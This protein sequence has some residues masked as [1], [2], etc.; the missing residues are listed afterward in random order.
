MRQLA[1]IVALVLASGGCS[2]ESTAATADE[3][4]TTTATTQLTTTTTTKPTT[5]TTT[6]IVF[7]VSEEMALLADGLSV[8]PFGTSMDDTIAAVSDAL[9]FR[10]TGDTRWS[11]DLML[12]TNVDECPGPPRG[13]IWGDLRLL[14]TRAETSWSTDGTPHFFGWQY[15]EPNEGRPSGLTTDVGI[16]HHSTEEDV[17]AAYGQRVVFFS[18]VRAGGNLWKVDDDEEDE[19]FL[20]G[21]MAT[22]SI[23]FLRGGAGCGW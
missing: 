3:P 20:G 11:N 16:G 4:T 21:Q 8:A 14:F 9:G 22:E 19:A 23:P 2:G 18:D 1:W 10:W 17:Y 12:F 7:P 6:T 13:I 15:F 5:T